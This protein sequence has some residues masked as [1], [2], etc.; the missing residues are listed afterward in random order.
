M[1]DKNNPDM[2]HPFASTFA[3]CF[4]QRDNPIS[5]TIG[6]RYTNIDSEDDKLSEPE[7][8]DYIQLCPSFF[9]TIKW[10]EHKKMEAY[11]DEIFPVLPLNKIMSDVL[12]PYIQY[13]M[14]AQRAIIHEV[15]GHS[16]SILSTLT[17]LFTPC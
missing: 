7:K 6:F 9:S 4:M 5:G 13:I 8:Q 12:P 14:F 16:F 17:G 1:K 2:V 11:P 3:Q 10:P 15:R